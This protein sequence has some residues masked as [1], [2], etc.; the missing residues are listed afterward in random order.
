MSRVDQLIGA[1]QQCLEDRETERA[2]GFA[3]LDGDIRRSGGIATDATASPAAVPLTS[4][5]REI[6]ALP[7][8]I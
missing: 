1:R 4:L 2:A 5:R 8:P 3:Q 6:I 7:A